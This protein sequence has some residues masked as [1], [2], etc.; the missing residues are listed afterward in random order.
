MDFGKEL[1]LHDNSV[2]KNKKQKLVLDGQVSRQ[3]KCEG[4]VE[5]K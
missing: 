3:R 1:Q 2:I 4:E 5:K